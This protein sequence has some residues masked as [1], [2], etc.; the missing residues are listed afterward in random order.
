MNYKKLTIL[1]FFGLLILLS[2]G[3]IF[4]SIW[5]WVLT[6]IVFTF[7]LAYQV[8]AILKDK[9]SAKDHPDPLPDDF[10]ILSD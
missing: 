3:F 8:I 7:L 2:F 9:E 6:S 10:Q 4:P 1:I 5:A